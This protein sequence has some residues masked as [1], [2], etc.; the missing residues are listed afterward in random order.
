MKKTAKTI[1]K[2]VIALPTHKIDKTIQKRKLTIDDR[3]DI[4]DKVH[5]MVTKMFKQHSPKWTSY[6]P[7]RTHFPDKYYTLVT[8]LLKEKFKMYSDNDCWFSFDG[9]TMDDDNLKLLEDSITSIYKQWDH[10]LENEREWSKT[11]RLTVCRYCKNKTEERIIQLQKFIH[12]M[13]QPD[14]QSSHQSSHHLIYSDSE[15]DSCSDSE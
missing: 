14:C 5:Q 3:T 15:S 6:L 7:N 10:E 11:E 1:Q 2:L 9:E 4:I 8:K 13:S 12:E